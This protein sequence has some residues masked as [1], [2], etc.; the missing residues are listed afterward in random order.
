MEAF[1]NEDQEG[2]IEM[3]SIHEAN[4]EVDITS[5]H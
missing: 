4:E 1:G 5:R 3:D 2:E